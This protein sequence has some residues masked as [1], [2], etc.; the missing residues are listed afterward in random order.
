[1]DILITKLSDIEHQVEVIRRDGSKESATLITRE[2]LRHDFAHFAVEFE[3]PIPMGYWGC[4]ASGA[5]LKGE[6][7]TGRDIAFAETLAGPVQTLMRVEADPG[8]FLAMLEKIQPQLASVELAN[9]IHERARSLTGY[10]KAT[11]FGEVMHITW[12][13]QG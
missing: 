5:S 8:Q 1:M 13:E 2:F 4:V 10:W 7:A 11:P 3:V 9:R 6:G 12:N